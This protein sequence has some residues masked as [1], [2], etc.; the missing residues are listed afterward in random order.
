M[1]INTGCSLSTNC[2]FLTQV[3]LDHAMARFYKAAGTMGHIPFMLVIDDLGGEVL[4]FKQHT[5]HC[6]LASHI[7]TNI[8]V[9]IWLPPTIAQKKTGWGSIH[10]HLNVLLV[11][12]RNTYGDTGLDLYCSVPTGLSLVRCST[13]PRSMA[14]LERE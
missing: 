9:K 1:T 5:C 10:M 3:P 12:T 13:L 2:M 14:W 6:K 4:A 11:D 7:I 8:S